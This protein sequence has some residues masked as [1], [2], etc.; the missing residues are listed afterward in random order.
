MAATTFTL[1]TTVPRPQLLATAVRAIRAFGGA[2]TAVVLLGD[3]GPPEA[4]VRDPR[5]RHL[6]RSE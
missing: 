4:G 2:A 5:P 1:V 3:Y 6:S